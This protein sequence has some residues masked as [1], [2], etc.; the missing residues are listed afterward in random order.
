M[1]SSH[2]FISS[3]LFS[4]ALLLPLS[5]MA[6]QWI[7][8]CAASHLCLDATKA[9]SGGAVQVSN[10]SAKSPE[11]KG[12]QW[13]ADKPESG[14]IQNR[15]NEKNL[16]IYIKTPSMPNEIQT[17]TPN[18]TLEAQHWIFKRDGSGDKLIK[19]KYHPSGPE[20]C[21]DAGANTPLSV[22]KPLPCVPGKVEQQWKWVNVGDTRSGCP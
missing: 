18:P 16:D 22:V 14:M 7:V 20:L 21:L 15:W 8:N 4:A 5:A 19:N 10:C 2:H 13:D 9:E 1:R 6:Q 17:I 3:A 11:L 12:Q